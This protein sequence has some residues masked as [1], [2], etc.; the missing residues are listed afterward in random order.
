M[1]VALLASSEVGLVFQKATS[2]SFPRKR[3]FFATAGKKIGGKRCFAADATGENN[4]IL[5]KNG[6]LEMLFGKLKQ[7][8]EAL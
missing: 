7:G 8:F 4:P 2:L 1:W 3:S 5:L 6:V